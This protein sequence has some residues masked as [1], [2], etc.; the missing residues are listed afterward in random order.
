LFIASAMK[1]K[2][3]WRQIF[4]SWQRFTS[5]IEEPQA[6]AYLINRHESARASLFRFGIAIAIRSIVDVDM[7]DLAISQHE[8][9]E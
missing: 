9:Q 7:K 1:T 5:G 2:G 4:E 3:S 6:P 8:Q